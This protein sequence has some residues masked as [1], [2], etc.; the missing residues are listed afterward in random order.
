MANEKKPSRIDEQAK[1]II[2]ESKKQSNARQFILWMAALIVGGLLG[3]MNNPSLNELFNFVATVFTRLFQFIAVPT[4]ALAVVTTLSALGAR[5][6]TKRIFAH[7]LI[8]TL[9]TTICS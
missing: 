7:T 1:E 4:I 2:E 3:W 5:K 9:L 6:D 8:Y